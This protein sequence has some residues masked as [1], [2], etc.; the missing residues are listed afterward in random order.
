MKL[1][2]HPDLQKG[3]PLKEIPSRWGQGSGYFLLSLV[4]DNTEIYVAFVNGDHTDLWIE[5]YKAPFI[6][7]SF[8]IFE[9]LEKIEDEKEFRAVRDFLI[10]KGVV[11]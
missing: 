6:Q 8:L 2:S 1:I 7:R 5:R 3:Q 4:Q 9:E 10:K 11:T